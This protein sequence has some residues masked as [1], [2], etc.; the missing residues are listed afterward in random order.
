[1]AAIA[2]PWKAVRGEFDPTMHRM[3]VPLMILAD[4]LFWWLVIYV[5]LRLRPNHRDRRQAQ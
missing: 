1:M 2:C 5:L 4:V 3:S